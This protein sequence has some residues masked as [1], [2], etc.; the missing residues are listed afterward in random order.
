V[1]RNIFLSGL[2][3]IGACSKAPDVKKRAPT[4]EPIQKP[5]YYELLSENDN[6]NF[7]ELP[8]HGDARD[9]KHFWSG[10]FWPSKKGSINR[11]W[12]AKVPIGF[13]HR[14][15]T[16]DELLTWTPE[17]IAQLSPSEKFD[18][19]NSRYDFVLRKEV[20]QVGAASEEAEIWEGMSNGWA[21]ASYRH[22]EPTAKI[23]VNQEGLQ[24]PFGSEDIK[25]LLAYYYT[26]H[27]APVAAAIAGKP[28]EMRGCLDDVSAATF[29]LVLTN[30]IGLRKKAF[31]MDLDRTRDVWNHPV[32]AY[33]TEYRG[34]ANLHDKVTPGTY[35]VVK[36]KTTVTY[37][38][39][40]LNQTWE[41]AIG[42]GN[43]LETKQLYQYWLHLDRDGIIIGGEWKSNERPDYLWT[44]D[45]APGFTGILSRLQDLVD[46]PR[47]VIVE[48]EVVE[49]EVIEPQENEEIETEEE[50]IIIG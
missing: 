7:I 2:L 44:I 45:E 14:A 41:P 17:K 47:P 30:S 37:I 32:V 8:L 19:L 33:E 22:I 10:N 16:L 18:L 46:D 40:A 4:F 11:R 38:G 23:L 36:M 49:P 15:P 12:S 39:E 5:V 1:N 31:L 35:S 9:Q 21:V 13:N 34:N 42:T 24:I 43:Q 29:H 25:G 28:C 27:Q 3:I 48:P 26:Y 50:V 6:R 20:S